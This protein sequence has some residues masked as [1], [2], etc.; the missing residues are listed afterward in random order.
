MRTA[1]D[2]LS[3]WPDIDWFIVVA[4]T[5]VALITTAGMVTLE[6]D[7]YDFRFSERTMTWAMR[8]SSFFWLLL[9]L[10]FWKERK[11]KG[12]DL[13][14]TILATAPASASVAANFVPFFQPMAVSVNFIL[15]LIVLVRHLRN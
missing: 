10:E 13:V 15:W 6:L 12:R 8:T 3:R 1:D 5:V 9:L 11:S 2:V 14:F 4:A 7:V